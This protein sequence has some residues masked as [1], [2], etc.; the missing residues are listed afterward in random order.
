MSVATAP[1]L[2][3]RNHGSGHS[4]YLDGEKVDG[5]TTILSKGFPKPALVGWASRETAKF[6]VENW[7]ELGAASIVDRLRAIEK[8]AHNRRDTQAVRGTLIHTIARALAEGKEVTPPEHVSGHV[9]SYLQF[10]EDW[11]VEDIL[12][13]TTVASSRPSGAYAGTLDLIARLHNDGGRTWILDFKTSASGIF[14]ESALQ[15]AAYRHADF[16]VGADGRELPLPPID[17]AGA[18][19]IR[20]DGYDLYPVRADESAF[21]T[22]QYAQQIAAAATAGRDHYVEAALVPPGRAA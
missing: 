3:R 2:T 21:R 22:F 4:Y 13:E 16:Y 6:A 10:I 1:R 12:V 14:M 5:V 7:D 9:D 11:D 18:V 8:A 17:A 15:L 19:W 20:A